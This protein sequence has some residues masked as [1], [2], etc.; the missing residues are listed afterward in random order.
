VGSLRDRR[1]CLHP[2]SFFAKPGQNLYISKFIRIKVEV[3]YLPPSPMNTENFIGVMTT[4]QRNALPVN[5]VKT[6][7]WIVNT[8]T[9]QPEWY[10]GLAWQSF[11]GGAIPTG[12]LTVFG[13]LFYYPGPCGAEVPLPITCG[14]CDGGYAR[15]FPLLENI[16]NNVVADAPNGILQPTVDGSYQVGFDVSFIGEPAAIYHRFSVFV[17]GIE[18]TCLA[19]QGHDVNPIMHNVSASKLVNLSPGDA[20]SLGVTTNDAPDPNVLIYAL[21]L[22]IQKLDVELLVP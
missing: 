8:T 14:P 10:D 7:V 17:N 12:I 9:N 19:L 21:R 6:G 20:V 2:A 11:G 4:A 3:L 22:W 16:L 5:L 15:I 13:D 1:G 18:T